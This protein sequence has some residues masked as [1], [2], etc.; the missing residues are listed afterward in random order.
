MVIVLVAVLMKQIFGRIFWVAWA[1]GF[2]QGVA[3]EI[4][5]ETGQ[6]KL[7][8]LAVIAAKFFMAG[9]PLQGSR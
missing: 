7:K 2:V 4:S 6:P 1:N 3:L 5:A 8:L 9:W